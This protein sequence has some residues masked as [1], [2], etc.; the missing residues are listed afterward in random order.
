VAI[1]PL[2]PVFANVPDA[3]ERAR[4]GWPD[5]AVD[6]ACEQLRLGPDAI[7]VELGA[8]TGKLT[9]ELLHRVGRVIPVEPLAEMRAVLARTSGVEA[10]EGTAESIPVV[11]SSAD[12]VFAAEAF[13]W[14]HGVTRSC[15][16]S[17]RRAVWR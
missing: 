3:Y 4:P 17:A 6:A 2:A 9:R 16:F 8:G 14:F 11:S 10:R 13:H 1:D 5:A 12:A 15:A 7:V